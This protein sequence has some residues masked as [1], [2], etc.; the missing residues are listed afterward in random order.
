[1]IHYKIGVRPSQLR[2][3]IYTQIIGLDIELSF[4][5]FGIHV[6]NPLNM[7]SKCTNTIRY[8]CLLYIIQ[9]L[10]IFLV[11]LILDYR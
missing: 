9:Y 3:V 5:Y 1:M 8:I 10:S 6:Y 11:R 7:T 2:I 4:L